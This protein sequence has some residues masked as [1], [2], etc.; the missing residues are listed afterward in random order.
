[1]NVKQRM[2]VNGFIEHAKSSINIK[3]KYGNLMS[4]ALVVL[5]LVI[6][7]SYS[8]GNV[9][10]AGNTSGDN[11]YVD[12]HGN[13]SWD[14][15]SATHS[16]L[17]G[18][19]L[20][21]Q[22]ATGTVNNDG[23]V[24]I[25]NGYYRGTKNNNI[26]ITKNMNIKGQ[27]RTG[28]I[29]S[30]SGTN[31]IFYI[32]TGINVT[33]SNLSLV[34]GT[35]GTVGL[36]DNDVS[37]GAINNNG[38]LNVYNS[39]FSGNTV[40]GYEN[41]CGGAISNIGNLN[42]TNC[43]FTNN[44]VIGVEGST[45]GGAIFNTGNMTI[46]YSNFTKNTVRSLESKNP[47]PLQPTYGGAILNSGGTVTITHS[48][49]EDNNLPYFGDR[50]GAIFNYGFM[51]ILDSSFEGNNACIG[52]AIDN[53]YG[54]L[55]VNGSSFTNNIAFSEGNG[56]AISNYGRLNIIKSTFTGNQ[57]GDG[58]IYNN[59]IL[60]ITYCNFTNNV[61]VGTSSGGA[62]ESFKGS[63]TVSNSTFTNNSANEGGAI[64][65]GGDYHNVANL[66]IYNDIFTGNKGHYG[67]AIENLGTLTVEKSTFT[68]NIVTRI[69][70]AIY[71]SGYWL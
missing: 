54:T 23:T 61:G 2:G 68:N 36:T 43:S 9:A 51:S 21:L 64:H 5:G 8:M 28:T 11:V 52:G 16:G 45:G 19:K 49:F 26:T 66:N 6:I 17:T 42:V 44:T 20:T 60:N 27:S 41:S 71:N 63:S 24:N 32:P 35:K 59:N 22:N 1:M 48:N 18:P 25:A 39:T 34:N 50:G 15:L 3:G 67:G 40:I 56:G 31:W 29:V 14:G 65:N 38:F 33:I 7:F 70:G 55:T 47:I 12:T 13:D 46:T 30:G 4:F 69:G 57:A 37:G 62:I 53:D 10:A 58:T